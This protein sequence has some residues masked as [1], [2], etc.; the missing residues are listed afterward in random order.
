MLK[1]LS[2]AVHAQDADA[3]IGMIMVIGMT[4]VMT[5]LVT[6][7]LTMVQS[8]LRASGRHNTYDG[9]L[10]AAESGI[11]QTLSRL[12]RD[13][14]YYG[15]DYLTPNSGTTMDPSPACN[16]SS[17]NAPH[18][19]ASADAERDWAKGKISQ[20]VSNNPS[21]LQHTSQ[22][23]YVVIKPSGL[24][25]VYAESWAPSYGASNVKSRLVKA[26]YLFAPYAPNDAVLTGCDL[27]IDSSTTVTTVPGEDPKLA[28]IH[29]NCTISVPNGNPTATGPVS[30]T[31]SSSA[32]SNKFT[33]NTGGQ[34]SNTPAETVPPITA[35]E[36]YT[37]NEA[38]YSSNWYDLCPDGTVRSP[39]SSGPCTGTL[40]TTLTNGSGQWRG[41]QYAGSSGGAA[42]WK[43]VSGA[44]DGIYYVQ[45]GNV[46]MGT[47]LGN[48]S[49]SAVTVI[50]AATDETACPK[51]GGTIDWDHNDI[52][53]PYLTNLFLLADADLTT[54]SNFHAGGV[55]SDGTV[56]SGLF[57]AGDQINMQTSSQGAYGS[58]IAADQCAASA[59]EKNVIKNP[60]IYYDPNA[61]APFTSIIN[62]TLWLE[63]VG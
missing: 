25:T 58:V 48:P 44:G 2:T 55:N 3:G 13:Y 27:E 43:L 26:E 40:L 45:G 14:V 33:D 10:T 22:G 41:F 32:S 62:T 61:Q 23:D 19:F 35:R 24:Q 37:M 7:M 15:A 16:S 50:A 49:S 1:R 4:L 63:Y 20:L 31:G 5:I 8:S 53:A 42:S 11:D 21:C 46:T 6:V 38:Q 51:V 29:S 34:V 18:S 60:S 52:S 59:G 47:G 56:S 54:E 17:I 12:Q 30:S 57:V 9:A 28:A 39:S 36:V